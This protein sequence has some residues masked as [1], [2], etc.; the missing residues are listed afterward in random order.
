MKKLNDNDYVMILIKFSEWVKSVQVDCLNKNGQIVV[1]L[2][3]KENI[4]T[5]Y[6]QSNTSLRNVI[7]SV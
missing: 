7:W 3:E 6:A 1:N 4:K 2:I 5:K